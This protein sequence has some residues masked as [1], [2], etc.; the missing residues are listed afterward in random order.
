MIRAASLALG[1]VV[2]AAGVFSTPLK[3]QGFAPGQSWVCR[4]DQGASAFMRVATVDGQRV[5]FDWGVQDSRTNRL[6]T[7]C[8]VREIL[9]LGEFRE[10][11]TL[12][13][14]AVEGHRRLALA[15]GRGG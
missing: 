14:G 9:S 12:L 11:C 4:T 15:C 6:E 1:T 5:G 8:G 10:F 7:L 3:A 13:T 2:A